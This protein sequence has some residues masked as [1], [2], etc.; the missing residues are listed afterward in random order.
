MLALPSERL[1]TSVDVAQATATVPLVAE[2][3][4]KQ[5]PLQQAAGLALVWRLITKRLVKC[6]PTEFTGNICA[7][8][9]PRSFAMVDSEIPIS[10]R[11]RGH[12]S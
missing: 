12:G 3:N 5:A 4:S 2:R 9:V 1:V 7:C 8:N 6:L 11:I 10:E